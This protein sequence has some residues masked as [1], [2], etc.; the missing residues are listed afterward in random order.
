MNAH[1]RL[2]ELL[3]AQE[4]RGALFP[5]LDGDGHS[6][7]T[8]DRES[9]IHLYAAPEDDTVS[10]ALYMPLLS[11]QGADE[12]TQ[13]R[14]LWQM[15]EEN[16]AGALPAGYALFGEADALAIYLGGQ[17]SA[18][19]LEIGALETR[20]D[21]FFRL[22]QVLRDRLVHVLE[23]NASSAPEREEIPAQLLMNGMLRI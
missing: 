19:H 11:L 22:G 18:E 20:T 4:E 3:T 16:A 13:L 7:L 2:Q 12:A 21:E 9:V 23:E 8:L 5:P 6:A 1:T 15:A 14:V 17:F 10:F